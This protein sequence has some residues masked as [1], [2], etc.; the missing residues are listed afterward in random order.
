MVIGTGLAVAGE[1]LA[2]NPTGDACRLISG[3]DEADGAAG[4]LPVGVT[5]LEASPVDR[6]ASADRSLTGRF[7]RGFIKFCGRG[8]LLTLPGGLFARSLLS[9][10]SRWSCLILWNQ[11][12]VPF[13]SDDRSPSGGLP[14]TIEV[15]E[16]WCESN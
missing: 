9:D 5:S 7:S 16:V 2:V 3:A 1:C 14:N 8:R 15:S 6:E 13:L 12:N 10:R 4:L 11:S